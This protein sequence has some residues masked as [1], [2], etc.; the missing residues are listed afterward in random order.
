MRK[1]GNDVDDDDDDDLE[2]EEGVVM[3]GGNVPVLY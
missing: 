1:D 2:P 3:R